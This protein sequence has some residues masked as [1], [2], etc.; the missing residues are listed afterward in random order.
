LNIFCKLGHNFIN[1]KIFTLWLKYHHFT[2]HILLQLSITTT[3]VALRE[4]T[5]RLDTENLGQLVVQNVTTAKDFK[6]YFLRNVI[7]VGKK[8]CY[9]ISH[10]LKYLDNNLK[11]VILITS[12]SQKILKQFKLAGFVFYNISWS[13]SQPQA[14]QNLITPLGA[15][16]SP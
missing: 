9:C 11:H 16:L 12:C 14:T 1:L 2:V 13:N 8:V 5:S 4:T 3:I 7:R 15:C 6:P 10:C